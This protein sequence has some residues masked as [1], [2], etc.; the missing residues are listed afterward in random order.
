MPEDA[1]YGIICIVIGIGTLI[2]WWFEMFSDSSY[3]D[4]CR[5]MMDSEFNLGRN[6]IAVIEPAIGAS[7]LTGGIFL[8]NRND[9][10]LGQAAGWLC[11]FFLTLAVLGVIPFPLPKPMYPEWQ[12]EKRRQRRLQDSVE[13]ASDSMS[14]TRAIQRRKE[15]QPDTY[16]GTPST[17]S[18]NPP[19]RANSTHHFTI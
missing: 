13:R 9:G 12:M 7:M 15:L 10:S 8:L 19:P 18:D 16:T 5:S 14:E 6:T 2:N 17:P 11:V 1:V 4:L 3:A